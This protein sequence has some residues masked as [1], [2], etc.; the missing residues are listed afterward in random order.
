[1]SQ[2]ATMYVFVPFQVTKSGLPYNPTGD[3]VQ[4]AFAAT[5]TYVPQVSDWVAGS[6]DTDTTNILYPYS[7]KC[8]VGPSGTITL[9]IGTYVIYVKITDYPEIP[10]LICGQLAISLN[11]DMCSVDDCRR[12][13]YCKSLCKTCYYRTRYRAANGIHADQPVRGGQFCPQGH[14]RTLPDALDGRGECREC[15]R[16]AKRE[17]YSSDPRV[18]KDRM[19]RRKYGI[20]LDFYEHLLKIQD[21]RC[22]ICG[23]MEDGRALA[24]DHDHV[25]GQVRGLL[26]A[27]CNNG[28]GRFKDDPERLKAALRYLEDRNEGILLAAKPVLSS[29]AS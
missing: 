24:V 6:W 10:V 11:L 14:D 4:F 3:T 18:Y 12:P 9:G 26:C 19:L 7:A 27:S 2:L 20:G 16:T 23:D 15:G 21:G 8:L 29:A 22:A 17:A 25:T 5:A 13:V 28:L 1:M